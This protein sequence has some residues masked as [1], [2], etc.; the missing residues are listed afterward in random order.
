MG[1]I[2]IITGAIILCCIPIFLIIGL[3]VQYWRFENKSDS[4]NV[5][6]SSDDLQISSS[7]S[8]CPPVDDSSSQSSSPKGKEES[9]PD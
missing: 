1:A 6:F 9:L 7:Q 2:L 5:N 3:G 4:G 8:P